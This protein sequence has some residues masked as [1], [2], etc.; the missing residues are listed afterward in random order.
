MYAQ[1]HKKRGG[2][3]GGVDDQGLRASNDL[4]E[5]GPMMRYLV[6]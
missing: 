4:Q 1:S 5:H 3:G 2:R 6:G